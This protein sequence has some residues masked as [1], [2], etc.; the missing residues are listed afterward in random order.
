MKD[1]MGMMKKVGEMQARLKDVQEELARTEVDG[2]SGGGLVRMTLDGKGGVKRVHID[3]SLMKPGDAEMLED[4]IVA[5]AT[6]A[7]GK[8]DALMK[9]KMAGVTGG[10]PLPPGLDLF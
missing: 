5:A 1:I 2:Q 6:D 7:R 3:P 8:A 9:S 10:L 4:L